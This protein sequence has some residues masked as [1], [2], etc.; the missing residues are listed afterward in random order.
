MYGLLALGM[1]PASISISF[2]LFRISII[3]GLST[4]RGLSDHW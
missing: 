1:F 4:S 2:V 3:V